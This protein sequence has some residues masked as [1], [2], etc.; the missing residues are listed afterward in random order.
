MR[1]K[2]IGVLLLSLWLTACGSLTPPSAANPSINEMTKTESAFTEA[3]LSSL[4]AAGTP[5]LAASYSGA[6]WRFTA[7]QGLSLIGNPPLNLDIEPASDG[8]ISIEV[9]HDINASVKGALFDNVLSLRVSANSGSKVILYLPAKTQYLMLKT[10]NTIQGN[11]LVPL[12]YLNL[13][14]C[15]NVNLSGASWLLHYLRIAHSA[16]ITLSN[17]QTPYLLAW[18]DDSNTLTIHGMMNLRELNVRNSRAVEF[19]WLNSPILTST[20]DDSAVV[21]AGDVAYA[22]MNATG[23]AQLDTKYLTTHRLFMHTA[24]QATAEVRAVDALNALATGQSNIYYY[25]QPTVLSRYYRDQGSVLYMG[26]KPPVCHLP[27]CPM[28]PRVLPG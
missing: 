21:L 16:H 28:P 15:S 20:I 10:F 23:H 5:P 1:M 18:I 24:D 2:G 6:R 27:Y 4:L 25:T 13:D 11:P 9:L 26:E 17:I 12:L 19:Y 14:G 8:K 22:N 7:S 3:N